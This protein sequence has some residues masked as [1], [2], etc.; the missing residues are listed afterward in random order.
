MMGI[1]SNGSAYIFGDNKYVLCNTTITDS[2]LNNK[3]Q[4]IAYH[5]VREGSAM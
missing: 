1:A 3:A 2:I 5:L 4:S